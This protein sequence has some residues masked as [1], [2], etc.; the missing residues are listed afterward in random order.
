M[1][2]ENELLQVRAIPLTADLIGRICYE[3][4]RSYYGRDY[5]EKLRALWDN[6]EP[7]PEWEPS[8]GMDDTLRAIHARLN[9][10]DDDVTVLR[11]TMAQYNQRLFALERE[12]E[13]VS[14]RAERAR[15]SADTV[16]GMER[17]VRVLEGRTS[18]WE[19][20]FHTHRHGKRGECIYGG[21]RGAT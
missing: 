3:L 2:S 9:T 5:A 1:D 16:R 14:T 4:G 11:N 13:A 8:Q 12:V 19:D 18:R 17:R 7:T 21:G 20:E 15:S 10:R 6:A